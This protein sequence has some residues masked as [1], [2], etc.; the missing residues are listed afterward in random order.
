MATTIVPENTK[1]DFMWYYHNKPEYKKKVIQ[2]TNDL[3]KQK[4]ETDPEFREKTIKKQ[5]DYYRNRYQTDPEYR[6]RVKEQNRLYM[7]RRRAAQ[8]SALQVQVVS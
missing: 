4:M 1:R 5:V 6:E 7:A 2:L 3:K 8:K